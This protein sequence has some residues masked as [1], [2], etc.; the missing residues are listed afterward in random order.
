MTKTGKET[1]VGIDRK[2]KYI[3]MFSP[4]TWLSFLNNVKTWTTLNM[5]NDRRSKSL[6]YFIKHWRKVDS[7]LQ[8]RVKK[9]I[10]PK[11]YVDDFSF[12]SKS[13]CFH[14]WVEQ[15]L[16]VKPKLWYSSAITV[17][18]AHKKYWWIPTFTSRKQCCSHELFWSE[19]LII[20]NGE[21]VDLI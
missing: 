19:L 11:A 1:A 12:K 17:K 15:F 7:K 5:D 16:C 21:T 4:Q 13:T 9:K 3:R 8:R 2:K 6:G 18:L 14:Y 20:L 10:T